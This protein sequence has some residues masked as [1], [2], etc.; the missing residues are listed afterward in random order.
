MNESTN[1]LWM[2]K[3]NQ[4]NVQILFD[5]AKARYQRPDAIDT[6][7]MEYI[8]YFDGRDL[9]L[10]YKVFK[11][12]GVDGYITTKNIRTLNF[13]TWW[14]DRAKT[15]PLFEW[16]L[17]LTRELI[18]NSKRSTRYRL[19]PAGK[20]LF[21]RMDNN[22]EL[23]DEQ[24]MYDLTTFFVKWE[25]HIMRC[26]GK[27]WEAYLHCL[28]DTEVN[29]IE[30]IKKVIHFEMDLQNKYWW[31]KEQTKN[32]LDLYKNIS[33]IQTVIETIEKDYAKYKE[34]SW[35]E[36]PTS[37]YLYHVLMTAESINLE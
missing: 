14:A 17:F 28:T 23:I 7:M 30:E 1:E 31:T 34:L 13:P 10:L 5:H 22:P 37:E 21:D 36:D 6:Q 18:S 9:W 4:D 8:K 3:Q 12:D 16:N 25:G 27:S 24:H 29:K 15:A 2:E 19:L 26:I 32:I 20:L 11:Q 35:R 33:D